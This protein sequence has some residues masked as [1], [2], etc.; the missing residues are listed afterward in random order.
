MELLVE[1]SGKLLY[2]AVKEGV[3]WELSRKGTPGKLTFSAG[4]PGGQRSTAFH[5]REAAVLWVYLHAGEEQGA[6]GEN[7][8]L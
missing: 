6:D 5:R 4:H 2:P 7:H 3:V 8:R 1:N